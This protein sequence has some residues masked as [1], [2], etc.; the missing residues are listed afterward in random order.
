MIWVS[1]CSQKFQEFNAEDYRKKKHKKK[2]KKQDLDDKVGRRRTEKERESSLSFP[3]AL[4]G[5]LPED[6]GDRSALSSR[7]WWLPGLLFWRYVT[8]VR[9]GTCFPGL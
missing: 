9:G 5:V 7:S 3:A 1:T 4:E 2:I 8:A 6:S